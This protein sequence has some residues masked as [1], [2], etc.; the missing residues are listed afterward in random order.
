MNVLNKL[1]LKKRLFNDGNCGWSVVESR[2]DCME[3]CFFVK[4]KLYPEVAEKKEIKC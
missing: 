4:I 3:C 2:T 1:F